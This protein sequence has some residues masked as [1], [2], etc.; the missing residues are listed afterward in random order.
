MWTNNGEVIGNMHLSSVQIWYGVAEARTL[1]ISWT[2]PRNALKV[3]QE[4]IS[5]HIVGECTKQNKIKHE[6]KRGSLSMP[7][8]YPHKYTNIWSRAMDYLRGK[9]QILINF[10]SWIT[11]PCIQYNRWHSCGWFSSFFVNYCSWHCQAKIDN[12]DKNFRWLL[13]FHWEGERER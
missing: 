3:N 12:C 4:I 1:R 2:S 8:I 11:F 13:R 7:M 10:D 5:C 9:T 6:I